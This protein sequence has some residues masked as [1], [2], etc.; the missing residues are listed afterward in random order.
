MRDIFIETGSSHVLLSVI[1]MMKATRR[2]VNGIS[3]VRRPCGKF[4]WL[5]P[6]VT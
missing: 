6:I 5:W 2:P 3:G 4:A 1:V